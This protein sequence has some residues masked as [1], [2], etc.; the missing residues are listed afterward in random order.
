MSKPSLENF[1]AGKP[2]NQDME[3]LMRGEED[4]APE[5]V[6]RVEN[7]ADGTPITNQDREYLRQMLLT[8][9]WQVLLKLLDT[10]LQHQEDAAR[11]FSLE[12][13][14]SRKDEIAA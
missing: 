9:G 10:E 1:L 12:T 3:R 7:F 4:D 11:R 6:A 2:H 8:P 5:V 14:F 13:P